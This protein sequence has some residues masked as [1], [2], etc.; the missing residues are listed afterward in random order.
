VEI[1]RT[2]PPAEWAP[3]AARRMV[4]MSVVE[5]PT[6]RVRDARVL[7]S[8]LV[9]NAFSHATG[10]TIEVRVSV[11]PGQ[12]LRIEVRDTG[13]G[14]EPHLPPSNKDDV[15]SNWAL[16]LVDRLAS[17]WGVEPGGRGC[18]WAEVDLR[19]SA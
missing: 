7:A 4:D 12:P 14:I 11:A 10:S 5:S 13:P 2:F 9:K 16:H 3:A 18:V 19:D 15:G 1:V 17:R 8:E 6:P